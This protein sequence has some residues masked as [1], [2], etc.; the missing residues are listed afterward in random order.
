MMVF[1]VRDT[2]MGI[3]PKY[4]EKIF[5]RFSQVHDITTESLSGTGLGLPL[6]KSIVEAMKGQILFTSELGKGSEFIVK[7]PIRQVTTV[8]S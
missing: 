1:K 3:A 5:E 7:L 8:N 4:H 6:T 2:G